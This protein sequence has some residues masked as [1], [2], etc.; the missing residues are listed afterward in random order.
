MQMTSKEKKKTV[1]FI[2]TILCGL[3]LQAELINPISIFVYEEVKGK[4]L[5]F[6]LVSRCK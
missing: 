2:R 5:A 3:G 6:G 4:P 1:N